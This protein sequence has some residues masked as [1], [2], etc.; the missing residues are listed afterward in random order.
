VVSES[1]PKATIID[2]QDIGPAFS[3]GS[4]WSDPAEIAGFTVRRGRP[5]MHLGGEVVVRDCVFEECRPG[6]IKCY[7]YATITNCEFYRCF[8]GNGGGISVEGLSTVENCVFVGNVAA[9]K[10]GAI[11]AS[12][13]YQYH[14][15]AVIR[16]CTLVGNSAG[17]G[18]G[19]YCWR[20]QVHIYHNVIAFNTGAGA[21][22]CDESDDENQ[23]WQNIVFH[24]EDGDSLCSRHYDN[25]F[26]D[27]LICKVYN[28]WQSGQNLGL[29][30]NSPCLAEN[31]DWGVDIGA[32]G[33]ACGECTSPV[34]QR[35]W[36]RVKKMYR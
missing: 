22:M 1:G 18:G 11:F 33:A 6:G 3:F 25:A 27:P 15:A 2:C 9:F 30:A 7:N 19:I 8:S 14:N 12:G 24:N 36:G 13:L 31:N 32:F 23:L 17:L 5:G 26:V 4:H 29:C 16:G 35:S 21:V 20:E 10:G 28:E 34:Y